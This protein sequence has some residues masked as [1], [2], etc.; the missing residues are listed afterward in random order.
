M[1]DSRGWGL[2]RAPDLKNLFNVNDTDFTMK[3]KSE[4]SKVGF[5]MSEPEI[6]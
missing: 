1:K 6:I 3:A 5:Y 4:E 2:L